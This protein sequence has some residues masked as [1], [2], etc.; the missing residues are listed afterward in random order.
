[1]HTFCM[2]A[3]NYEKLFDLERV[4]TFNPVFVHSALFGAK[5]ASIFLRTPPVE[6]VT[7]HLANPAYKTNISSFYPIYIGSIVLM[8][9]LI[10][11]N[12][13]DSEFIV[14]DNKTIIRHRVT[15]REN[16]EKGFASKQMLMM[17][18]KSSNLFIPA[19]KYEN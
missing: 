5:S 8:G 3:H 19:V 9:Y 16:F 17:K 11:P 7:L 12:H 2:P 18:S 4:A 15:S 10:I 14:A 6:G 1:M 13:K